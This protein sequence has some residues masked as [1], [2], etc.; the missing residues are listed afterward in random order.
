[1][2]LCPQ[3]VPVEMLCFSVS[4]C[5]R[6]H[7]LD[8][9]KNDFHQISA[10]CHDLIFHPIWSRVHCSLAVL[11]HIVSSG[12]FIGHLALLRRLLTVRLVMRP[13]TSH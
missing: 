11:W 7:Q 4:I 1:M 13:L 10:L 12:H 5:G 2:Q 8:S 9:T 3:Y 6:G